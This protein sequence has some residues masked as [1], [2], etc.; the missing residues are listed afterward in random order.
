ML[1]Q[2]NQEVFTSLYTMKWFF[3]CFLDRVSAAAAPSRTRPAAQEGFDACLCL[4]A[5]PVH[6]DAQDLGHLHPGG[7]ESAAGHVL[8]DPQTAQE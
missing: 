3:Q 5:D 2:D 7:G 1:L 4:C 8:H 6:P